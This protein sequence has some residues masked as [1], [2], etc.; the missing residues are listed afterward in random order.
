MFWKYPWRK[1]V[2][3]SEALVRSATV[4]VL[5]DMQDTW[6]V[7]NNAALFV[8]GDVDPAGVRAAVQKYFGDWKKAK[9]PWSP[10]P[11]AHPAPQKDALLVSP[12]SRCTPASSP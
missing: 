1:D 4:P 12:T 6:Y 2:S 5:Q 7:P 11:P 10:P 3:G 8:G 9:D